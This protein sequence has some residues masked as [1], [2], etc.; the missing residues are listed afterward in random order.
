MDIKDALIDNLNSYNK[1]IDLA[2]DFILEYDADNA[3]ENFYKKDIEE[4]KAAY[5]KEQKEIEDWYNQSAKEDFELLENK[6]F[7]N[8]LIKE[9]ENEYPELFKGNIG[10]AAEGEKGAGVGKTS[11]GENV[12]KEKETEPGAAEGGK[13]PVPPTTEPTGEPAKPTEPTNGISKGALKTDYNFV[14]EFESKTVQQ[15]ADNAMSN[16]ESD[17]KENGISVSEQAE[18]EVSKMMDKKGQSSEQDIMTAAYHLRDLDDQ[19]A[20]ANEKGKDASILLAKRERAL[21]AL[22]ALGNRAGTNLRL[23]ASAYSKVE[24]NRLEVMR[25]SIKKDLGVSDL[26][27]TMTE[28][29]ISKMSD[30]DKAKVKPYVEAIEE[31]NKNLKE[32]NDKANKEIKE[33]D[34]KEIEDYIKKEIERRLKEEKTPGKNKKSSDK[35]R[36][37]AQKVRD[38]KT[39][40]SLGL[41]TSIEASTKG[42]SFNVKEAL[43][44]VLESMA[45]GV[46]KV[47]AIS[48]V[49]KEY[50]LDKS[51]DFSDLV[52]KAIK[53]TSKPDLDE[54]IDSIKNIAENKNATSITKD[55]VYNNHINDF[56]NNFIDSDIPYDKVIPEATTELKNYLPNVTEQQ[57]SDAILKRGEFKQDTK[58]QLETELDKKKKDVIRLEKTKNKLSAL[59]A[60]VDVE[61]I[62]ADGSL[63]AKEKKEAIEKRKSDYEKNIDAEIKKLEEEKKKLSKSSKSQKDLKEKIDAINREIN[64][65]KENKS[66]FNSAL[67]D[68]KK[69]NQEIEQAKQELKDEYGKAGIRIESGS[70]TEIK[71]AQDAEKAIKE[72]KESDLPED[73]KDE[74]IK[75]IEKSRN[76]QLKNTKQGVLISLKDG[77][78]SKIDELND[79]LNDKKT[80]KE[81]ADSVR[82]VKKDL[83]GLS[84]RLS[85]TKENLKDQIDKADQDLTAL[86]KTHKGTEYENDLIDIQDKFRD[87]WQQTADD[88]QRQLLIDK[89]ERNRKDIERQIN[90]GQYTS[91]P[92]TEFD[93]KRDAVVARKQAETQ[94]AY[95]K[96]TSLAAKA[97]EEQQ[98]KNIVDKYNE[99]RRELMIM[100]FGALEKVGLSGVTKPIFDPLIKQT[101]GRISGLITGIKP[102]ELENISK[103][104]KQFKTQE[105]ADKHIAKTNDEYIS[106]IINH[107]KAVKDFGKDSKEAEIAKK[108]LDSAEIKKDAALAFLYLNAGSHIDIAQVMMNGATD[109]DAKMGKYKQSFAS[110]RTKLQNM[111]YLI[112]SMNRT[113]G[114][115]KSV[116]HRQALMDEYIENL[117]HF[118]E[119]DGK[120]TNENRQEAWNLAVERSEAGRFGEETRLSK[121]TG[122]LKGSKNSFVRG[123]ANFALAV[124]KIGINMTKQ[125]IDM[126]LPGVELAY[127]GVHEDIIKGYNQLP[128]QQK[129]YINTLMYRGLFGLAQYALI[130]YLL[131]N[132]NMKYG[133]AYNPNDRK[134]IIG[135]DG[136]PLNQGEWELNGKRMPEVFNII[137]NHSPY[138]LPASI[139][140]T[141]YQNAKEGE[142]FKAVTSSINEVYQRLPFQTSADIMRGLLGDKFSAEKSV[143]SA[144]PNMNKTA[145][146]FDRNENGEVRPIKVNTGEFLSTT[147]NLILKGVPGGRNLIE[148]AKE[149]KFLPLSNAELN[150]PSLGARKAIR[151]RISSRHPEGQMTEEEY[152]KFSPLVEKYS[153]EKYN[154]IIKENKSSI[155]KITVLKN[156]E[157]R[158]IKEKMELT[159]L[160]KEIGNLISTEH[161]NAIKEAKEKLNLN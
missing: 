60:G 83:E 147:K 47:E 34:K 146:Y 79:I 68:P 55:M 52:D 32:I 8:Q 40:D 12:G 141:T 129:K 39:L 57:V 20:A 158:S 87:S 148:T 24:G 27:K 5:E 104:Y 67:K 156:K 86:I 90:A 61:A 81:T 46:D 160:S 82:E 115:I 88:I 18:H 35:L 22:R 21:E 107:E 77:I 66:A 144:V 128:L 75:E 93:A 153:E 150:I 127:K 108:K 105:N 10:K 26:P 143:A 54:T 136:N 65:V 78:D 119:K 9:Y 161:G 135:S 80:D 11:G 1:R 13:P 133:G 116:S 94:N 7:V 131:A 51:K 49:L 152:N 63:S 106:A 37:L 96:L 64:H 44:K 149:G 72:I 134:K 4:N 74:H 151:V 102:T 98:K 17:A 31:L 89:A 155:D 3:A 109:F 111:W 36:K 14:K 73:V 121:V 100:S 85:P 114:A 139:A 58:K 2:K 142:G 38:S 41:G 91:I 137:M 154:K 99:L 62:N 25:A 16:L 69:A 157:S 59:E 53:K 84:G 48:K 45:D 120:I 30:A 42:I 19:I 70:K 28:L 138:S 118:Q 124:A 92:T 23:F 123:A 6:D 29:K 110:E 33:A 97:K 126:A 76:E 101:F 125:G 103:T 132:G 117:Q 112:Q 145:E 56:V 43:A 113:H 130:G 95:K 50:G 159:K 71:I 122:A 140:A 15:I